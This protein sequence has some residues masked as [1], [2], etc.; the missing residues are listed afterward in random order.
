MYVEQGEMDIV[1]KNEEKNIKTKE[2][3][4]NNDHVTVP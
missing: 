3:S 1:M 2:G 4:C